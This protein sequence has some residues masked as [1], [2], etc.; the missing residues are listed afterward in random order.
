[1]QNRS[2]NVIEIILGNVIQSIKQL[3]KDILALTMLVTGLIIC[4]IG[5]KY[6]KHVIFFVGFIVGALIGYYGVPDLLAIFHSTLSDKTLLYFSLALGATVG[7]ICVVIYKASVFTL[8]ATGGVIVGEFVWQFVITY[9]GNSIPSKAIVQVSV[10]IAFA[11]VFGYLAFKFVEFVLKG[12]TAFVGS[13]MF[14]TSL[15]YWI[16]RIKH[17]QTTSIIDWIRFFDN[18]NNVSNITATCDAYCYVCITVWIL[19]FVIGCYVQY[20]LHKHFKKKDFE[21]DLSEN[22]EDNA[23][24]RQSQKQ[25]KA[26][27]GH[28]NERDYPMTSR[29]SYVQ[30]G[31]NKQL[32]R[33][34][35]V[36][37]DVDYL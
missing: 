6:F 27:N 12:V 21:D 10:I 2:L 11:V 26:N 29:P 18:K 31:P 5:G 1:L 24:R 7:I 23:R 16:A 17:D 8:G 32:G 9:W 28:Y 4:L 20:S 15:A 36:P 19:L 14:A 25:S 37:D 30:S 22:E 34:Q 35:N 13:F 3:N 33:K